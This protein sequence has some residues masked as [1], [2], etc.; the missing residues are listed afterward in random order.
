MKKILAIICSMTLLLGVMIPVSA[1]SSGG[2]TISLGSLSEVDIDTTTTIDIPVS[3]TKNPG[4]AGGTLNVEFDG[5]AFTFTKAVAGEGLGANCSFTPPRKNQVSPLPLT[6]DGMNPVEE[7]D[8]VDGV[9]VTLTFTLA[10][11]IEAGKTYNFTLTMPGTM[12]TV[13]ESYDTIEYDDI[14]LAS[15]TV[16]TKSKTP[17]VTAKT[18][19]YTAVNGTVMA[20]TVALA[21]PAE[22]KPSG[23]IVTAGTAA[24]EEVYFYFF[25]NKGFTTDGM[26]VNGAEVIGAAASKKYTVTADATYDFVFKKIEDAAPITARPTGMISGAAKAESLTTFATAAGAS[27]FGILIG[28]ADAW[29]TNITADYAAASETGKIRKYAALE[30]NG[31]G[32]FAIEL[33]DTAKNFLKNGTY[34][35]YI[36]AANGSIVTFGEAIDIAIAE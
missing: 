14:T 6:F 11:G 8:K 20:S 28:A 2:A 34:K 15:G 35:A 21:A 32:Q 23:S 26:T 31:E 12:Y 16:T 18:V 33:N 3:I 4:L 36:Y 13:D 17:A 30:A 22:A 7:T 25:P 1:L 27:E 5:S 10:A 29:G 24:E 9:M 19:S